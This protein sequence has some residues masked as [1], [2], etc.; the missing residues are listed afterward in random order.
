M[1]ITIPVI[2]AVALIMVVGMASSGKKKPIQEATETKNLT[3]KQKK[4]LMREL[5]L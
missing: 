1:D 2:G 3:K 5:G 4:K